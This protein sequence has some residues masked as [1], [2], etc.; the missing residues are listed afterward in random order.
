MSCLRAMGNAR[1]LSLCE[2]IQCLSQTMWVCASSALGQCFVFYTI[3]EFG[4]LLLT[5]ITTTR[6]A[7]PHSTCCPSFLKT[8]Q[9]SRGPVPLWIFLHMSAVSDA[10]DLLHSV[11]GLPQSRQSPQRHAVGRVRLFLARSFVLWSWLM[12]SLR[13]CACVFAGIILETV[14]KQLKQQSKKKLKYPV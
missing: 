8:L 3:N 14:H 11:F 9:C 13:R 7:S 6:K 1:V 4:P 5:T 2:C 10:A 12:V